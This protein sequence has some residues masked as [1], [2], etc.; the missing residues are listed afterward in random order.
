MPRSTVGNFQSIYSLIRPY[1]AKLY[2]S[3]VLTVCDSILRLLPPLILAILIDRVAG[4]GL[5]SLLG[6]LITLLIIH[7]LVTGISNLFNIYLIQWVSRRIAFDMRMGMYRRLQRLS[8]NYF[9]HHSTGMLLER[10]MSDVSQI[11]ILCT[12]QM[13]Q[14]VLDAAGCTFALTV[15]FWVNWRLTIVALI[16]LPLYVLNYR[17]CVKRIRQANEHLR[18]KRDDISDSLQ[19]NLEGALVVKSFGQEQRETRQYSA[20]CSRALQLGIR[21]NVWGGLFNSGSVLVQVIAQSTI[22]FLGCYLVIDGRMTYG[23]VLAF[24]AYTLYILGPAVRFS[25]L[26]NQVE[27]AMVSVRR[28][29]EVMQAQ[30]DIQDSA[31]ARGLKDLRGKIEL[32]NL[33][34]KYDSRASSNS[35]PGDDSAQKSEYALADVSFTAEPGKMVALVGHTGAGKTSI[36]KLLFRF[37]DPSEGRVLID[38]HDI[39]DVR[40]AE[41]RKAIAL[42]PQEPV[43]FQATMAENIAYG[44]PKASME[45]IT[46][47]AEIAELHDVILGLPDGYDTQI[48]QANFKLS[49]G[50]RQRVAIAR[51]ILKDPAILILDEATSSLDSESERSIQRALGRMMQGKTSLVIAHRLSTIVHADLIV[52]MQNTRV[53]Q[54]GTH[55]QL[56]GTPGPYRDLYEK[57][58]AAV[59]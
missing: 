33:W 16:F 58:F 27:Q 44:R 32:E 41:L 11:Q 36:A 51:A 55:W 42:V 8:L 17:I 22:L 43:L 34:F 57:Q 1:R 10:L 46:A 38:D 54:Q 37:Y 25:D 18:S 2:V 45:E 6:L 21:T 35:Q 39:R 29:N 26:F 40:L 4:Q 20:Q 9:H 53:V 14:A 24:V 59:A 23:A 28:V 15:M 19:Q 52:V 48:G 7:A 5:W 3:L 31:N 30:P 56:L 12:S 13:V 49:N 47:A 50:Q